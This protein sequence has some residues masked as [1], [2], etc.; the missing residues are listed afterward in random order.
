M[1]V[2]PGPPTRCLDCIQGADE[3]CLCVPARVVLDHLDG[4]LIHHLDG[5]LPVAQLT[6]EVPERERG[7][8]RGGGRSVFREKG[9][10]RKGDR[11]RI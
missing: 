5:Q 6:Q 3:A 4:A 2:S 7:G 1:H 8:V 9:G 11:E 10:Q